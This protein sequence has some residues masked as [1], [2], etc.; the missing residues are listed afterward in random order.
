M[1]LSVCRRPEQEEVGTASLEST[2]LVTCSKSRDFKLDSV[3]MAVGLS[4]LRG[5][6]CALDVGQSVT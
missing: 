2:V 4:L 5:Y 1:S 3:T 6:E